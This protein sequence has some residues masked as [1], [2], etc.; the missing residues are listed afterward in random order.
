MIQGKKDYTLY[1]PCGVTNIEL[2]HYDTTN[3]K[4][5]IVGLDNGEVRIYHEKNLVSTLNMG[6]PLSAL[7][8][9]LSHPTLTFQKQ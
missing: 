2:L 1:M 9:R 4:G 6:S 8:Y 5:L 3:A 7:R